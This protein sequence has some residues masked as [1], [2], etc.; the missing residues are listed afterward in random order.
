[1]HYS[2]QEDIL[3]GTPVANRNRS[4]TEN[5]IGCFINTLVLRTNLSG[6]PTFRQLLGRV[7]ETATRAFTHQDMPFE[8]LVEELRPVRDTSRTP[9]FQVMLSMHS[10]QMPPLTMRGLT[11]EA[12]E[13]ELGA[14]KFDLLL[15][16]RDS[17]EGLQTALEF[18]ADLFEESYA[19]SLLR[20]L[21][22][23]LKESVAR[24]DA[25]LSALVCVVAEDERRQQSER[26][27]LLEEAGRRKYQVVRRKVAGATLSRPGSGS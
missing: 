6:D 26:E 20:Q 14:S 3:V 17:G 22:L 4:E 27:A 5:L 15:N 8:K 12:R 13:V 10:V 19:A 2:K 16:L 1:M 11:L 23:L 21:E 9:L 24:P 18:N 25:P 7:R